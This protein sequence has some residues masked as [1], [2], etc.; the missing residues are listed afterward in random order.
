MEEP[1]DLIRLSIDERVYVKCRNN[2]ELRGKL[3][4]YDQHLN[5]VLGEVEEIVTTN[6]ID[7]ETDEEIVKKATRHVGM[8]FVRGDIVVLVSPPIRMA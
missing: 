3:H 1:L 6:E 8:L 5:M 4:A 7:E 2:R